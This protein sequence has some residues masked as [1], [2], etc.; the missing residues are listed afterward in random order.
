MLKVVSC[1]DTGPLIEHLIDRIETTGAHPLEPFSC[2][3]LT[4]GMDRWLKQELATRSGIA[5]NIQT[6]MLSRFIWDLLNSVLGQSGSWA[7][8]KETMQVSIFK[9][10]K[11]HKWPELVPYLKNNPSD[12]DHLALAGKIADTFDA[13]S[14]Y[15]PDWLNAWADGKDSIISEGSTHPLP[16]DQKWQAHMWR[17]IRATFDGL[18]YINDRAELIRTLMSK[19]KTGDLPFDKLPNQIT[20]FGVSQIPQVFLE[21]LLALSEHID[22]V[23]YWM[24]PAEGFWADHVST[25]RLLKSQSSGQNV[26]HMEIGNPLLSS[27]GVMGKTFFNQLLAGGATIEELEPDIVPPDTMLGHLQYAIRQAGQYGLDDRPVIEPTDSSI[28][29]ASA[30]SVLREVEALKDHLLGL[31]QSHPDLK[32]HDV[33]VMAPNIAEYAPFVHQVFRGSPMPYSISDISILESAP[34]F[35]LVSLLVSI[36]KRRISVLEL[37][38]LLSSPSVLARFDLTADRAGELMALAYRNHV[39]WGLRHGIDDSTHNNTWEDGTLRI[40]AGQVFGSD[41]CVNGIYPFRVPSSDRADYAKVALFLDELADWHD[42]A[43]NDK[44]VPKWIDSLRQVLATLIDDAIE[45]DNALIIQDAFAALLDSAESIGFDLPV[46]LSFIERA[47]SSSFSTTS[48]RSRFLAGAVNFSNCVPLRSIPFRAICL[49]GLNDTAFPRRVPAS[50][51][52]LIGK[53]PRKGDRNPR[54]DDRYFILETLLLAKDSVYLSYQG[55]SAK[56][57]EERTPSTVVQEIQRFLPSQFILR[58]SEQASISDQYIGIIEHTNQR[59]ALQPFSAAYF[60]GT[61][62]TFAEDWAK[63]AQKISTNADCVETPTLSGG[64]IALEHLPNT[65]TILDLKTLFRNPAALFLRTRYGAYL[66]GRHEPLDSLEPMLID[67]LPQYGLK[68]DAIDWLQTGRQE[69]LWFARKKA[70]GELPKG[71][72]S[73]LILNRSMRLAESIH[74]V[75]EQFSPIAERVINTSATVGEQKM[76]GEFAVRGINDR[77]QVVHHA[78]GKATPARLINLWVETVVAVANG[79]AEEGILISIEGN[80]VGITS[81]KVNDAEAIF[82]DWLTLYSENLTRPLAMNPDLIFKHK[83]L[84][85]SDKPVSDMPDIIKNEWFG[86][87]KYG[88]KQ[89]GLNEQGSTTRCFSTLDQ[90]SKRYF[91]TVPVVLENLAKT[92]TELTLF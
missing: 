83:E 73:E 71:E 44:P 29:I 9:L 77:R 40:T 48:V 50:G 69:G 4:V 51:M 2:V 87:W 78:A 53:F 6:P 14:F 11:E 13:Y 38:E 81:L 28:R 5:A 64:N 16:G 85:E 20:L 1:T 23:L 33:A 80:S 43:M 72:L 54:I 61:L 37:T 56:T 7:L 76:F 34:I 75:V 39:R 45:P 41:S 86:V 49:L 88:E 12:A 15:R 46:S 65:I 32:P 63:V 57:N 35:K 24:N 70:S 22:V 89:P 55:N 8:D 42:N 25:K 66:D 31:F 19:I 58:G 90:F 59:N 91:E 30:H 27:F 92:E 47:L 84:L 21:I 17:M 79:I 60:D 36:N 68:T 18:S 3:L 26:E 74:S 82:Q 10:M 52:D 62:P 67:A